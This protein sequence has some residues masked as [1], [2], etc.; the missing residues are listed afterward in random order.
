MITKNKIMFHSRQWIWFVAGLCTVMLLTQQA[1]AKMTPPLTMKAAFDSPSPNLGRSE[2][3]RVTLTTTKAYANL[4]IA[5][6]LPAEIALVSGK[7]AWKG[8]LNAGEK[9]EIV[10]TVM[11]KTT[12]RYTI[13][14]NA[15]FDPAE[16]ASFT[17]AQ[18]SLN[19]IAEE[20]G[21]VSSMEEFS[22]MDLKRAKTP[23]AKNRIMG[24]RGI[25]TPTPAAPSAPAALPSFLKPVGQP[26]KPVAPQKPESRLNATL[27]VSVTVAG[28]MKYKDTAG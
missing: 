13:N 27:S 1:G 8:A 26:E 2:T 6:D 18:I 15:V 16:S 10:L 17:A 24:G 28:Y 12:G 25:E 7:P 23:A 14:V 20:H 22:M 3:L 11:L 19:V 9:R 21:V 5:V 4:A